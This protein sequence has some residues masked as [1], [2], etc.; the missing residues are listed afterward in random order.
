MI[1]LLLNQVVAAWLFVSAL[2]LPHSSATS[3]NTI[4]VAVAVSAVAF[5][6]FAAPGRPGLRWLSTVIAVWLF[7][8]A[9]VMPHESLGTI[10]HDVFVSLV[11]AALSLFPPAR[12]LTHWREEHTGQAHPT[13]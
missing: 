4:L 3:W 10:L 8:A 13:G 12:W 7:M 2:V 11:L 5:L 6:A 1:A 9:L